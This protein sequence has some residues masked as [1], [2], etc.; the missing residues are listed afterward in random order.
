MA[1]LKKA[2]CR[3][4]TPS[5]VVSGSGHVLAGMANCA[6]SQA[7]CPMVWR[8]TTLCGLGPQ[9]VISRKRT[10]SAYGIFSTVRRTGTAIGVE[11]AVPGFGLVTF[12][13]ARRPTGMATVPVDVSWVSDTKT[14]GKAAPAK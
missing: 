5:V 14:V 2:V 1:M 11:V 13:A 12:T 4:A 10:A 9:V 7:L 3:R 8:S 6:A